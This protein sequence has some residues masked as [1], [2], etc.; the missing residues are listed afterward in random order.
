[1]SKIITYSDT[2]RKEV[3]KG[4]KEVADAVKVTM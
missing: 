2:A 3:Y 4:I 1:M